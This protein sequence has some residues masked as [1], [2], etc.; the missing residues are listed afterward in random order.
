MHPVTV[1]EFRRFVKATGYV[2]VAER[3]AGPGR[4]SRTP[5]PALLVPGS[6]VFQRRARAGRPARLPQLVGV[7]ARRHWQRPEGPASDTYTR[8]RH[9]VTQIAYADAVAYAAWAGKALPTEA[10]WEYAAR[11]GL[12][13]AVFAWGDEFA[14]GGQ[15]MAN[16]LAGRVPVAE[17]DD[18]RLRRHVARRHVPAQRL[19]AATT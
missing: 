15:M 19:R 8:G 14:P 11:G 17:P 9:P 6:L 13:G 3:A 12:D 18:R 16:T 4:L 1:A 5:I 10:E 7:R 2:T